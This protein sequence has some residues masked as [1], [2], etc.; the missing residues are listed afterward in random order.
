MGQSG[1]MALPPEKAWSVLRAVDDPE[2]DEFP[3]DFDRT[4]A[5]ARFNDLV[6]A[7]S[8]AFACVCKVDTGSRVQD[9][10]FHGSV[11]VPSDVARSG[12]E[13]VVR[14]SNLGALATFD[15]GFFGTYDAAERAMRLT[16]WSS[17]DVRGCWSGPGGGVVEVEAAGAVEGLFG[18]ACGSS[19]GQDRV[20]VGVAA[21]EVDRE[22]P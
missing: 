18:G 12:E 15:Q 8:T 4:R 3:G 16:K 11:V 10:S 2:E 21:G 14:V 17:A 9:A 5:E 19:V 22:S 6:R 7:L 20:L 13:L 1:R